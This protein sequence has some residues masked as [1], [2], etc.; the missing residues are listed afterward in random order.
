M[1]PST[2]RSFIRD[3]D[4]QNIEIGE[5][6][7]LENTAEVVVIDEGAEVSL[8]IENSELTCSCQSRPE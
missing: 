6:I 1:L 2:S 5:R 3:T 8:K 4:V 7:G